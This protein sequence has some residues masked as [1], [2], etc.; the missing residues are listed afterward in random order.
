MGG[1]LRPSSLSFRK[2]PADSL[3]WSRSAVTVLAILAG[4]VFLPPS[5]ATAALKFQSAGQLPHGFNFLLAQS[6]AVNDHNGHIYVADSGT[7]RV[8]D[9]ASPADESP[10]EWDGS[11]TPA[12]SF[13]GHVSVAVDNS[14]GDVYIADLGHGVIDKFDDEG[15]LITSF[16]DT[17]PS[18]S[19]QLAG[20]ATPAGSFS[21]PE[22][23]YSSFAIAVDQGT[24]DLYAVDAHHQ[25][26]DVFDENGAYLRQITASAGGL[27]RF[28]GEYTTALAVDSSGN[29][30][31]GDWAGP[32]LVFQFD[33]SGGFVRTLDGSNTP[34]GDFSPDSTGCC[35]I[36][37]ATDDA[38]GRLFVGSLANTDFDVFDSSGNFIPPQGL[39][40]G[41]VSGIAV[42]Q[43]TGDV[44]VSIYGSVN[45]F[46]PITVPNVSTGP[47][48]EVSASTATLTGHMDPAGGG[49]I[50]ECN[51]EY[52]SA[53]SGPQLAAC[54]T[55][56]P[57]NPPYPTP[58]DVS[59]TVTGLTPGTKYTYRLVA[60]NANGNNTSASERAVTAGRY[61]FDANIG[62]SG[63][64]DGQLLNPQ[65][66]A[67]DDSAG[68]IYVADTDNHRVMKFDSSGHFLAAWGWGVTDGTPISEVCTSG[69][70]AGISGLGAGQF[71]S[72]TF[73][74]VDNSPGPSAGD[75]YVAD[76]ADNVVQKFEPS[77]SLVTGWGVNGATTYGAGIAG[78]AVST[79]GSLVVEEGGGHPIAIDSFGN[80]VSGQTGI[81]I[82]TST[83]DRFVD[84]GNSIEASN[85]IGA[86]YDVF[87]LGN[88][89]SSAGVAFERSSKTVYVADAGDNEVAA[90]IP[91][92]TPKLTTA[93]VTNPGATSVTVTG[94]VD[95]T[96]GGEV[97]DCHF[98]YGTNGSYNLGDVPCSPGLP[99][100]APA[101]V[102]AVIS[103]LSPFT[104][105]HF[106]LAATGSNDLGFYSYS[107]DL[108]FTTVEGGAPVIDE[109]VAS[110]P[111]ETSA[112]LGAEVNP[113]FGAT[114][115]RFE[116]GNSPS[117]GLRTFPTE[118]IEGDGVDHRAAVKVF[119]LTP[120]TTYHF[121][122]VATNFAGTSK[123]PDET[124][125]TQARQPATSAA[126]LTPAATP[127]PQITVPAPA[128]A[129]CKSHYVRR[130]GR[131]V[132]RR[133]HPRKHRR[134]HKRADA[135]RHHDWRIG[136]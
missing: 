56:P 135:R 23:G 55:N 12:G 8:L 132:R 59:T 48:T 116:Y 118:P 24:H 73:I 51:F 123:G 80:V 11:N 9:F 25:V 134:S 119:E 93:L 85:V 32:N 53:S 3:A 122:V 120:E 126:T 130:Q 91:R 37:V 109:T 58:T 74:E 100:S 68:D 46:K 101:N 52:E 88:L 17:T 113:N 136:R 27:Y 31:A 28:G 124:F 64:G 99:L 86:T 72:P 98:E 76:V 82:D 6:V 16:G 70:R 36:S 117:Y 1:R 20:S 18:P 21:P 104:T 43:S 128:T 44:Y 84:V 92:P 26:I 102:S 67:V 79:N 103:G 97:T 33:S 47:P 54:S 62:A 57:S 106:R 81:A 133:H 115:I 61:Q 77:G 89:H 69:C 40:A 107:P 90:F 4:V 13:G 39:G 125:T 30:Y 75:I 129:L 95:P 111:T 121:R 71:R 42:D 2:A 15:N 112:T 19:G 78:M 38:T 45:I 96:G 108:S 50:T 35:L 14:T 110:N 60:A 34:D 5:P 22:S 63:S 65:D 41:Y 105:Y 127:T 10:T 66:V 94:T 114:I 87:G 131:C 83:D 29:V 7:A 49:P